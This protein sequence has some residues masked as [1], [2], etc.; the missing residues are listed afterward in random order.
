MITLLN[1]TPT[2]R[3][4][5]IHLRRPGSVHYAYCGATHFKGVTRYTSYAD[6]AT[7]PHCLRIYD[8]EMSNRAQITG[9]TR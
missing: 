9:E 6:V 2:G 5:R 3:P 7:C 4:A 8:L 1:L